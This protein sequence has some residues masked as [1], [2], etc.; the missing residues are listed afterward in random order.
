[1]LGQAAN[2]MNIKDAGREMI[3]LSEDLLLGEGNE[4]KC[5]VH[6]ES[7]E[8]CVKVNKKHSCFMI[9]KKASILIV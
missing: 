1:M 6:P 8:L 2:I 5:Y 9:N 7:V 4:R 3:V